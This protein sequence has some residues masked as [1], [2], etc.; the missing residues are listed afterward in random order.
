MGTFKVFAL[1]KHISRAYM[2]IKISEKYQNRL[3]QPPT[4][5]MRLAVRLLLLQR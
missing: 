3:L 2:Y 4:E 5:L 1:S